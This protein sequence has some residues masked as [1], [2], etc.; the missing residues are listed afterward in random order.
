MAYDMNGY[1]DI[2]GI[3]VGEAEG[4]KF[5]LSVCNDLKN[6]GVKKILIACMEGLK[7]LPDAIKTVYPDVSIQT[8]IVH[9]IR[10]SFKYIASKDKKDFI[11]NLKLVYKASSEELALTSLDNLK[12]NW[13]FKYGI[14]IDCW[15]NNW[16]NLS[17]FFQFSPE[18]RKMIYTTNILEDFNKQIRKFTKTRTV[19]PTEESLKKSLYL[20]T[21]EIMEKWRS[22]R[23]NW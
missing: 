11:K 19:F 18:I 10:N 17:N 4:A 2:L 14:V 12:E 13:G 1:K 16:D 6:R 20:A 8:C 23:T 15:Y 5:W 21:M 7:G 3:W 22:P 9:Q